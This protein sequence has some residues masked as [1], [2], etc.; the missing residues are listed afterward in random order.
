MMIQ[1]KKKFHATCF[2]NENRVIVCNAIWMRAVQLDFQFHGRSDDDSFI[3]Y[4]LFF[5]IYNYLS[6]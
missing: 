1:I 2:E 6:N 4:F 3:L 5:Y